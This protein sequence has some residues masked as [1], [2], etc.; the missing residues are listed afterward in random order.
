MAHLLRLERTAARLV[1]EDMDEG[2]VG[3]HLFITLFIIL[4]ACIDCVIAPFVILFNK[5][6]EKTFQVIYYT[7][8]EIC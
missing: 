2:C 3:F 6:I 1:E 7:R 5:A 8:K 4:V